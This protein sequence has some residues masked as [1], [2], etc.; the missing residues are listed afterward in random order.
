ML[1]K[2][3]VELFQKKQVRREDLAEQY[4][5]TT[6]TISNKMKHLGLKWSYEEGKHVYIGNPDL[7]EQIMNT[8]FDDMFAEVAPVENQMI[9]AN[10]VPTKKRIV[11]RAHSASDDDIAL[12]A[13]MKESFTELESIL[14]NEPKK[15]VYRG[16][17]FDDDVLSI[18]EKA[19]NG[20]K[21]KFVNESLRAVFK[22]QG[23]L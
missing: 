10:E 1:V 19:P 2:E 22:M 12:L 23:L 9:K 7:E 21:S 8:N 14:N 20:N 16:F 17:Y 18:I 5:V 13:Q 4:G 3:L 15:K 6:R 11:P